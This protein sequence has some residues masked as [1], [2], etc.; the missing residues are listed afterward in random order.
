MKAGCQLQA[1]SVDT[2]LM[3][4][5]ISALAFHECISHEILAAGRLLQQ[6]W[7]KLMQYVLTEEGLAVMETFEKSLIKKNSHGNSEN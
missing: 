6:S 4:W 5:V 3:H 2:K 7:S 1:V